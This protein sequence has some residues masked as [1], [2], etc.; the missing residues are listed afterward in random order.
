MRHV[1]QEIDEINVCT[2][3]LTL[4]HRVFSDMLNPVQLHD[5]SCTY[6]LACTLSDTCKTFSAAFFLPQ[7]L[8]QTDKERGG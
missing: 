8:T 7:E 4:P 1:I 5:T 3:S 2:G 6:D